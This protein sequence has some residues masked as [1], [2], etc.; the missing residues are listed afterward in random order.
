MSF[1]D[2]RRGILCVANWDSDVGYAWW[3]MESFWVKISEHFG[4]RYKVFLAYP[5]ISR[6][7]DTIEKSSLKIVK[8]D[9]ADRRAT[10]ILSQLLF[11]RNNR[12]RYIY[13]SDKPVFSF[14][15]GLF[16]M[17][18]VKKIIVHDHTPGMRVAPLG[19]KKIIKLTRG[20]IPFFNC[21]AVIGATDFVKDRCINVTCLPKEKCFSAPNGIPI[22]AGSCGSIDIRKEFGIPEDRLIVVTTGRVSLYKGIEFAIDVI[23]RLVSQGVDLHYIYFGDG[24]DLQYCRKLVKE[25]GI[26][27]NVTFAGK[28]SCI[29]EYLSGCGV[30]FHPSRGEV[31]YSLSMLE[32]MRAHLPILVSN[33]RSVCESVI[34]GKTGYVYQEGDVSNAAMLLE[35]LVTS[36]R[37]RDVMGRNARALLERK[38]NIDKCHEDLVSVLQSLITG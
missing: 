35:L 21:D 6:I 36:D 16:R 1:S 4:A 3:L 18:G 32:Y 29:H 5:S 13:F 23:Y 37:E 22:E 8:I 38:Y 27:E 14:V 11:I 7:P 26:E 19:L 2:D 12:I 15:Y 33:N 30:A 20:R 17:A 10:S 28:V 31:G 34:D 25:K 24:P 9:F